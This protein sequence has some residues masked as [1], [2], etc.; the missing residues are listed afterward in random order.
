MASPVRNILAGS[1]IAAVLAVLLAAPTIVG[2][3]SWK[4][5]LGAFGLLLFVRSY[6]KGAETSDRS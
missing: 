6:G 2:I 3:S 5:V 4:I 1:G